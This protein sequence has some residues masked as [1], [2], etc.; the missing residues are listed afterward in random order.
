MKYP[1]V[2]APPT[3]NSLNLFP[4]KPSGETLH[5]T[6]EYGEYKSPISWSYA[7]VSATL[8]STR[9]K[10]TYELAHSIMRMSSSCRKNGR[11]LTIIPQPNAFA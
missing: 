5:S 11:H 6:A 9:L 10:E 2:P 1:S 8:Y 7:D 4:P 3:S